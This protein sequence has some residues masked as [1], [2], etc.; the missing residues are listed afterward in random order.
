MARTLQTAL[1]TKP[2]VGLCLHLPLLRA[3]RAAMVQV[4]AYLPDRTHNENAPTG[5]V[6]QGTCS[7]ALCSAV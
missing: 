2:P 1:H 3:A 4:D 7:N 5:E 6:S